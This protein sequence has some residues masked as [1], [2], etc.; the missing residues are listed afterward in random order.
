MTQKTGMRPFYERVLNQ[1]P[2]DKTKIYSLHEVQVYCIAK[3]KDHKQYEY[4]NKVSIASTAQSNLIVGVV[5]HEHHIHDTHT[6]PD[7]LNHV[8]QSRGKSAKQAVMDRGYPGPSRIGDTEIVR[9]KKPLKKDNRY[10]RHKKRKQCR[11]RAAIEPVIGHL[12]SDHRLSRNYLKGVLG[13]QINLL[14]AATAWN[15]KQWLLL[16]L[17]FFWL[18]L[19]TIASLELHDRDRRGIKRAA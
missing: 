10:Q 18:W 9:P 8:K 1:R 13:D 17:R 14:M 15:L 5:S 12:K 4:G 6:L 3:G 16:V 2:K 7:V 11:R 19:M